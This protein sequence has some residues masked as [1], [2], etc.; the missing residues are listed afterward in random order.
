MFTK[1]LYGKDKKGGYKIW[2][3]HVEDFN[4]MIDFV[5]THGKEGGKMQTQESCILQ[6]KQGR[7]CYEQGVFE[8]EAKIKTQQDKGYREDK[9]ELEELPL[10]AMLAA[11]Y[12]KQGHRIEYPCYVPVKY[13][14]VRMV[15]KCVQKL[16]GVDILMESR[17]GQSYDIPHIKEALLAI[18]KPGDVLDGEVY[19]HGYVLQDIVS[20]VKR[21]DTQAELDKVLRKLKKDPANEEVQGELTEAVKI[22][23]LRPRLEFHV[24]DMPSEH[25]F[26]VRLNLLQQYFSLRVAENHDFIRLTHYELAANE[27]EMKELHKAAVA[28]G[29]EG[30]MLRN[31]NGLYESGKRSA[32]LQKYKEFLDSEFEVIGWTTDKE[33]L[34]VWKLKNDLNDNEFNV[35]F[36]SQEQKALWISIADS[37]IG[38]LLT[39]KYQSRYKDTLLPQ[40]PT[41]V[42]FR[43]YE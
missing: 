40:F 11:D 5:I 13:D 33:G 20:A 37:F 14:G 2:T 43:D 21:T 12:R 39:V 26:S 36:G 1:T 41:G 25:V 24:F 7:S 23:N 27:A 38:K 28:E 31:F 17:T 34:I 4:G 16:S 15:A 19:K 32:D 22:H 6:G 35:I 30:I 10:L 8:A 18:M 9:A 42:A 3:I 29:Y